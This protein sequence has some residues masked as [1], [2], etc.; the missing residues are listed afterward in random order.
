MAYTTQDVVERVD[1]SATGNVP[2]NEGSSTVAVSNVGDAQTLA[3]STGKKGPATQDLKNRYTDK[4]DN[5]R[6]YE[7]DAVT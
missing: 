6:Y 1:Q 7:G 4:F 2:G 5:P 3:P